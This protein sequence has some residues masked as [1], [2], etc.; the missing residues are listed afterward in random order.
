MQQSRAVLPSSPRVCAASELA[1][2]V[3][4]LLTRELNDSAVIMVR[5]VTSCGRR[6]D[7]YYSK[8][9]LSLQPCEIPQMIRPCV[10]CVVPVQRVPYIP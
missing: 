5:H 3:K 4:N 8:S 6:G 2:D 9:A 10:D 7:S 1:Q